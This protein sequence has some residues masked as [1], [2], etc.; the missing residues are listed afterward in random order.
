MSRF[1][2]LA[3]LL[4]LSLAAEMRILLPASPSAPEKTAAGQLAK[5]LPLLSEE[6]LAVSILSEEDPDAQNTTPKNTIYLGRTKNALPTFQLSSW[7]ALQPDEILYQVDEDG[8]LWIAGE[9][10]RGTLYAAFELLEREYGARFFT[11]DF[12]YL[13]KT[14]GVLTLPAPGVAHRYAPPFITRVAYYQDILQ[15][16]PAF[17]VKLRNNFWSIPEEWGG[18]DNIIGFVHTMERFIPESHF[19][20]HPEWFSYRDGFRD[21]GSMS[22]LCLTNQEMRQELTRRVLEEL[23]K[24]GGKSHFISV[25]QNDNRRYC[26]CP[27]CTAFVEAHGNQTD[28]LLDCVNQV[29]EAVEK[30]FP[31]V[32]VDTLA[33]SYTRQPPKTVRPRKNVAIR[34]CTIE[35]LSFFPLESS[36]NQKLFQEMQEWKK[37]ANKMLIWNYVTDFTRYYIPHPNWN[38]L[39]QDTRL[40]RDCN[41]INIFQQG[42]FNACGPA[43][44]LGDLRAYLLSRLLWD[45][46]ADD[47]ALLDEF[48][49]HFYGPATP[50]VKTYLEGTVA[51]AQAHPEIQDNCYADNT[52][53]WMSD[54][55]LVDLWRRVYAGVHALAE[56]PVYGPRMEMAAL[57]LTMD[58]LDRQE[59][60]LPPPEERLAP[61]RD[62]DPVALS[63]WCLK[64]MQRDGVQF[65]NENHTFTAKGWGARLKGAFNRTFVLPDVPLAESLP[66][67]LPE[68]QKAW[69]WNVETLGGLPYASSIRTIM[70]SEDPAADGGKAI[71]MPN[72]HREWFLQM[73]NLPRGVFDVY[74]SV[75]CDLKPGHPAQG[76][77]M[78]FGNYPDGPQALTTATAEALAGPEYKLIYLGRSNLNRANYFYGAPV[79]NPNVER[80]W[81][82]Q[83][84]VTNPTDDQGNPLAPPEEEE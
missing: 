20:E 7:D 17:I 71:T 43:A 50:Y 11:E 53:S 83:F 52:R 44:D 55:E 49:Q 42:A 18:N 67:G 38:T 45:P 33:Y 30:E 82:D 39:A 13:P 59:L 21:A 78:T 2:L 41:A 65:L 19:Q 48:C 76:V 66:P 51:L 10:T 35:A 3:M 28:L 5:Y 29:A 54:E 14:Q 84:V 40:F 1:L 15:G 74:L 68:G 16:S 34:Y 60:L 72:T 64:V 75:R 62:V 80:V 79:I 81:F 24:D 47:Q 23:R 31:K 6:P 22:Q 26:L 63:D 12:E 61:L 27:E 25:S 46:D 57:P 70:L 9:G 56:D 69:S 32:Y 4:S 36:Q 37:V 8:A 73:R 77:A 58:L